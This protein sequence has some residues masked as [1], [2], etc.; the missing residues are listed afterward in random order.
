VIQKSFTFV[1]PT[2]QA[3]RLFVF[4]LPSHQ[5]HFT[6]LSNFVPQTPLASDPFM[7]LNLL[8]DVTNI[9][10]K[11]KSIVLLDFIQFLS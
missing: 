5:K 2:T 10:Q 9:L 7:I 1:L 4:F 3:E 11:L 6:F 8:Q